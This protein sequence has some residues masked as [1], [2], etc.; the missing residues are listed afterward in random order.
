MEHLFITRP[1]D[2]MIKEREEK[3]KNGEEIEFKAFLF[4]SN[5][6]DK[7]YLNEGLYFNSVYAHNLREA[8]DLFKKLYPNENLI[9]RE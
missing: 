7:Y 5:N 8:E 4:D 9:I 3:I 1:I 6:N 2:E